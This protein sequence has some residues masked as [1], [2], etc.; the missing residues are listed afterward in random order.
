[1][2]KIRH[3]DFYSDEWLAGTLAL[4]A[5]ERGVYITA[6]ALIYSHG[7]PIPREEL[8][9]L[10]GCHGNAFRRIMATLFRLGKLLENGS[11]I[12]QKRCENELKK[13]RISIEKASENGR[14]GNEIKKLKTA[15]RPQAASA[16]LQ[17]TTYTVAKATAQNA[18]KD[19]LTAA[20]FNAGVRVLGEHGIKERQAR[21]LVGKWRR[22]MH[23]DGELVAI[24]VDIKPHIQDPVAYVQKAIAQHRNGGLW[25]P[26]EGVFP[27]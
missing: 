6:C 13:A 5:A 10:A 3:V 19:D 18:P 4:D 1:L 12:D 9:R 15:T 26:N 7:G 14:L 22:D 8:Q 23:D 11:E 25:P 21:T 27:E 2:A 20:A 17:P 24:L 16:N